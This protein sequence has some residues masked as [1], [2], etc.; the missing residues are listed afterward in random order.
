MI[1]IFCF[2][3]FLNI[4][5]S[6]CICICYIPKD[7][8]SSAESICDQKINE[9]LLN[10]KKH[11]NPKRK[12][13]KAKNNSDPAKLTAQ[14]NDSPSKLSNTPKRSSNCLRRGRSSGRILFDDKSNVFS[15]VAGSM[16]RAPLVPQKKKVPQ[17]K[18]YQK[19]SRKETV[20]FCVFVCS[21][22]FFLFLLLTLL[23]YLSLSVFCAGTST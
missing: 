2:H 4:L 18:N 17:N 8:L 9:W 16:L 15:P 12:R 22:R 10:R 14:K 3:V 11:A 21:F 6:F 7:N 5:T 19:K 13:K 23:I 20:R 1:S